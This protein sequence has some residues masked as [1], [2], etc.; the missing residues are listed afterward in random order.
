MMKIPYATAVAGSFHPP[1]PAATSSFASGALSSLLDIIGRKI[2]SKE[3]SYNE[4]FE[5]FQ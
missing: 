5:V 3:R 4:L 2:Y 1:P